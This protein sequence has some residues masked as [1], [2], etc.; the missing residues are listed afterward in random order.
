MNA[1]PAPAAVLAICGLA[2]EAKIAAGAG[3]AAVAAPPARLSIW[4]GKLDAAAF[5]AVI[6][7]GIAGGLDP[8]LKAGDLV[9]ADTVAEAGGGRTTGRTAAERL[10][11]CLDHHGIAAHKGRL[12]AAETPVLKPE[13]KQALGRARDAIAVDT[14]SHLAVRYAAEHGLPFVALRAISDPAGHSLPPLALR[15][16][17]PDGRLDFGAILGELM[18]RPGQIAGLPAT[19]IATARAMR[20]LRG[21]RAVLGPGLGLLG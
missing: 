8:A 10:A 3:I 13:E 17:G 9:L 21:V 7:F 15:A 5:S 4:L 20:S 1:A 12:A 16:I 6:S 2:G 19:G 18:R 11:R 14:E